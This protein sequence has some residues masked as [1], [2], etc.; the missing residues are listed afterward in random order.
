MPEIITRK[1]YELNNSYEEIKTR[2]NQILKKWLSYRG[3]FDFNDT[4]KSVTFSTEKLI[5][6]TSKNRTRVMLLCSNPH[7]FSVY[8]GMFLSPDTRGHV[9]PF[10]PAMRES[11]WLTF[12]GETYS[13]QELARLC[14][15]VEYEGPFELI[16]YCYYAFPTDTPEDINKIFGKEYFTQI[17]APA[18][19]REFQQAIIQT[20]PQAVVT[21]N[22]S[23]FNLATNERIDHYIDRLI[24]GEIIQSQVSGTDHVIP[25]FLTFPT[26][27]HY[28]RDQRRLRKSS[29]VAIREAI[30]NMWL[31]VNCAILPGDYSLIACLLDL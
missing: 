26:G 18:S 28:H 13:P 29:L 24:D 17:I 16:F 27:W 12:T 20:E 6:C 1:T 9:N 4:E 22:K 19:M 5:P 21:F 11:G 7:P 8:Q 3:L 2:A 30:C 31:A 23:I 14:L 25:V 15:N 10:W